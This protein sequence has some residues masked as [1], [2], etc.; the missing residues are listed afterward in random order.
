MFW[1]NIAKQLAIVKKKVTKFDEVSLRIRRMEG[2]ENF[3]LLY[4]QA[5][6]YL[7]M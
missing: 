2:A 4:K 5:W 1:G 6:T 3:A 7:H